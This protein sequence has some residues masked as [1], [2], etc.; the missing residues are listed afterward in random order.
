MINKK[1]MQTLKCHDIYTLE[2]KNPVLETIIMYTPGIS[3]G[4]A[5]KQ[6]QKSRGTSWARPP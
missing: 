4:S 6:E 5:S 3:I 1:A 2:N